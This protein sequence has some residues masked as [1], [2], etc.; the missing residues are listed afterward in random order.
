MRLLLAACLCSA[1]YARRTLRIGM[2]HSAWP[3]VSIKY[4]EVKNE[5]I[6]GLLVD[7]FREFGNVGNFDVEFVPFTNPNYF[8]EITATNIAAIN[9]GEI[10]AAFDV[11]AT[12]TPGTA[13]TPTFLLT[14]NQILTKKTRRPPGYWQIFSPF[15]IEV[16]VTLAGCILFGALVKCALNR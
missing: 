15:T 6:G 16:W 3:P 10:D 1:A 14:Y 11:N 8:D 4:D 13:I 9:A 2:W 12:L 7:L 5:Y